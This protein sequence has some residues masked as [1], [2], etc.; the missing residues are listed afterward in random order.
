MNSFSFRLI[1]PCLLLITTLLGSIPVHAKDYLIELVI[2]ETRA[3]S[4]LSAGGL[5][6]PKMG[7]SILLNTE[8]AA[9]AGFLP[10]DE[11]LSLSENAS[12]MVSS[13]R[14]RV[15][16]HMA[17]R[18]PG[19]DDKSAI[20]VLINAGEPT[21]VFLPDSLESNSDFIP[22]S[23]TPTVEWPRET[24]S[25]TINGTIKVRLGRFLHMETL[26]VFTDSETG[27]GFRLAQS[28]KMRSRE[29]HYIDNPRFGILTR[30]LPLDDILL[31]VSEETDSTDAAV[32]PE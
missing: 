11:G 14:Y 23:L 13:G 8:A 3:G 16:Q 21:T 29:L 6:Y 4:K 5:Y 2:F 15:F 24:P 27:Q 9:T 12:A 20:A 1:S 32:S 26:L 18:Q 7:D 22:A 10:I 28:R 31:T 19:L 17:W 25:F 30:I